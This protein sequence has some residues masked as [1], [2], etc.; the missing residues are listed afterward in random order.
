[1]PAIS[2]IIVTRPLTSDELASHNYSTHN[3]VLNSRNLLYYYR[4]LKDNR[5][6]FGARGDL[7]GS[8][9]SSDKMS[10]KMEQQMKKVFPNWANVKIDFRWR[11]LVAVT[12]KF[13]PS[14]GKLE[15]DEIYYSFGYQANGVNTAPWAGKELANLIAG[16][17]SKKLQISNLYLGLPKKFPLPFLRLVYLRLAYLYY[18]FIDK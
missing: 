17:N 9:A 7:I 4:L 2:N 10:K 13:T 1:L 15:N 18:N 11:G 14:I 5:F 3:P 16:L 8:N 12:T 6:L